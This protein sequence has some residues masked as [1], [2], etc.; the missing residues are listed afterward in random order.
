MAMRI[1]QVHG[2]HWKIGRP[3]LEPGDR[4]S[5]GCGGR[6]PFGDCVIR[7]IATK[8]DLRDA[9][10]RQMMKLGAIVSAGGLLFAALRLF[11]LH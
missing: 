4:H 10:D 8:A 3:G 6:N 7:D 5:L 9:L 11:P 1:P 2:G